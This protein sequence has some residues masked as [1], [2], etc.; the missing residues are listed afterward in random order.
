MSKGSRRHGRD[1]VHTYGPRKRPCH[2]VLSIEQRN[3]HSK[4]IRGIEH[5]QVGEGRGIKSG[6]E[7]ADEKA[8]S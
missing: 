8:G 4:V 2:R 7:G 1:V 3:A 6:F 5:C